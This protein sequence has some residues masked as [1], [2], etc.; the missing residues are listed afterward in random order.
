MTRKLRV[1]LNAEAFGFGPSAAI[2]SLFPALQPACSS[3]A[4]IGAGHSTD[5]QRPLAYTTFYDITNKDAA[6]VQAL[7]ARL[8]T[9]YDIFVTAL[10]FSMAALAQHAGITTVI[11]DPLTW[12][13]PE[14]PAAA[15]AADLYLAQNF[16]GVRER[17][18]REHLRFNNA[19]VVPPIV[20]A[21]TRPSKRSYILVNLGGLQNPYWS[22]ADATSYARAVIAMLTPHLPTGE[23]VIIA[24][25]QSVA[26]GLN[27]PAGRTYT[28][29]SM[30]EILAHT[31]YA[32]MTPGLGNIYDAARFSIPTVWLPPA[33]DSQG[34]QIDILEAHDAIDARL[35]WAGFG[36]PV[37]YSAPQPA[38]LQ[39]ITRNVHSLSGHTVQEH[40]KSHISQTIATVANRRTSASTAL[41]D[42]FGH[43]GITDITHHIIQLGGTRKRH[44]HSN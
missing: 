30:L 39:A 18:S 11:Y 4:Y 13:W 9:Q 27:N 34:Q 15:K 19:R 40:W 32:C 35:D 23:Q 3:I 5:L 22:P 20:S 1:L 31:A 33:N 42:T 29:S 25:S 26:A 44:A 36:M 10:D 28:R 6:D 43:G 38:V 41:L 17:L 2:A 8:S 21:P 14:I 24:T 7:F 37:T 16:Y 12:Y